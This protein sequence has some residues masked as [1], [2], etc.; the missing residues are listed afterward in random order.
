[1]DTK[2]WDLCNDRKAKL[3]KSD[4]DKVAFKCLSSIIKRIKL[5]GGMFTKF[6][7]IKIQKS[8]V[9]KKYK[10]FEENLRSNAAWNQKVY[11][12]INMWIIFI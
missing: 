8:L 11:C 10:L 5:H 7:E 9:A 1:M 4:V 2:Y 12:R 3:I 6:L